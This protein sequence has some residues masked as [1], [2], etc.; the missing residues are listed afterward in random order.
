M[1]VPIL[2][3]STVMPLVET[4]FYNEIM[5]KNVM[6]ETE[7]MEMVVIVIVNLKPVSTV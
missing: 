3:A 7:L 1:A 6:M 5:M 4:K 2:V